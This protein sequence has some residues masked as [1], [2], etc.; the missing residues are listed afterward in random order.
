MEGEGSNAEVSSVT[1]SVLSDLPGT[2]E[3]IARS[4]TTISDDASRALNQFGDQEI[5]GAAYDV[6][7]DHAQVD[8]PADEYVPGS[9]KNIQKRAAAKNIPRSSKRVKKDKWDV[10]FVT[11]NPKSPLVAAPLKVGQSHFKGVCSN[12]IDISLFWRTRMPSTHSLRIS[13]VKS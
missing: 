3:E 11:Q 13:R 10:D 5:S 8:G 2:P 9:S 1:S 6:F 7:N 12:L 4:Y